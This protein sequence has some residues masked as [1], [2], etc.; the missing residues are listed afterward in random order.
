MSVCSHKYNEAW[1]TLSVKQNTHMFSST[2]TVIILTCMDVT[3]VGYE[4]A[5]Y[6]EK[7]I[8]VG[9]PCPFSSQTQYNKVVTVYVALHTPRL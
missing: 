5:S 9:I 7:I 8:V 1:P 3:R 4:G 6:M 2:S